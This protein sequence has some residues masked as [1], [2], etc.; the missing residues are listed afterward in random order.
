MVKKIII[1]LLICS[2]LCYGADNI[3][4]VVDTI[5]IDVRMSV[6]ASGASTDQLPDGR[7]IHRLNIGVQS[8]C[9]DFNA[10]VK[11]DTVL[12]G[13]DSMGSALNTDFNRLA[14]VFRMASNQDSI[15]GLYYP[16]LYPL[17][18]VEENAV[19]TFIH[20]SM[21]PNYAHKRGSSG[22]PSLCW[23]AGQRL[24]TLPRMTTDPVVGDSF[25]V[26]YYAND[27]KVDSGNDS[28]HVLAK[29]REEVVLYTTSLLLE[30][31]GLFDAANQKM[32]R[33]Q[34]KIMKRSDVEAKLE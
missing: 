28:I 32:A 8:V 23:A 33:Y 10:I 19:D 21:S 5:L 17:Q 3:S 14:S 4:P 1:I 29:Y 15:N 11:Y 12:I 22:S 6:R 9:N 24:F 25:F 20:K 30:D 2:S 34:S 31:L 16:I 18:I 13:S 7:C 26:T 27:V